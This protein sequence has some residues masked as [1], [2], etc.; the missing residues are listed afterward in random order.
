MINIKLVSLKSDK[1]DLCK[2]V[3]SDSHLLIFKITLDY[4]L[5]QCLLLYIIIID[6]FCIV[7]F[8]TLKQTHC[9]YM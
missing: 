5:L 7:L 1:T 6:H 4:L 3:K 8:S 9:A 2:Y